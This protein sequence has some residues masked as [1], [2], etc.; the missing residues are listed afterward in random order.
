LQTVNLNALQTYQSLVHTRLQE[1]FSVS[2]KYFLNYLLTALSATAFIFA[3]NAVVFA[4][5]DDPLT[6]DTALVRLNIGVVD[7]Q[8]RP[9]MNLAQQNF[10]V[11]EDD[12]KQQILRFEPT[13]APFSLVLLLDVSGSTKGFRQLMSQSAA[14]FVDA[15]APQDR[16]A[17]VAFNEKT[18]V[19]VDFTTNKRDIV[20]AVQLVESQRKGGSTMLYKALNFSLDK[21]KKEG[22]RRKAVVVLTDG[23]DTEVEADDR[24]A[25]GDS[26]PSAENP[27]GAVKPEQNQRLVSFLDNAAVQGITVYPLALPSG[28]PKR[29]AQPTPFQTA[30]YTAAR[31]RLQI[32]ANRTGGELNVIN[33]LEQMGTLY[34]E[35]AAI[36]RTLYSIEYQSSNDVKRDGK[37]RAIRIEVNS[38]EVL[39]KTRPGY[40]AK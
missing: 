35:V 1:F 36:L 14:R 9:Q 5:D 11:Y 38:P 24:R 3:S 37:W 28:D 31:E 33:R 10:T 17:V 30:K 25:F 15:L 18:E 2:M 26:T 34:A 32:V 12:V 27:L 4:Q 20:Y 29:I 16:V 39:A 40:Y 23:L 13:Q 7:R 6:V 22:N 8:G 21:L 19:L